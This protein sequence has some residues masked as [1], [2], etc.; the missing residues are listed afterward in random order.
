QE[1]VVVQEAGHLGRRGGDVTM[2]APRGEE[3][4]QGDAGLHPGAD[5]L[6]RASGAGQRASPRKGSS[7]PR[8]P[9]LRAGRF[10]VV[11][12]RRSM[13]I[14]ML[15]AGVLLAAAVGARATEYPGWGDTGWVYASKRECCNEA[16]GIASQYSEQACATAGGTPSPFDGG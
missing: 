2:R 12:M 10:G 13:H 3:H 7:Q 6:H 9:M 8:M 14:A 5:L 16:I 11:G 4:E 1:G 15:A